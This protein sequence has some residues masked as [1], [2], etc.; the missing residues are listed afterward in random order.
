[1]SK[2]ALMLIIDSIPSIL[3]NLYVVPYAS[4]YICM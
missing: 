3:Q 1:M 4:Y 2:I